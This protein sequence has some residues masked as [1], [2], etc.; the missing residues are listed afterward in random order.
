MGGLRTDRSSSSNLEEEKARGEEEEEEDEKP[1][2]EEG[3]GTNTQKRTQNTLLNEKQRTKDNEGLTFGKGGE[4]WTRYDTKRKLKR[5]DGDYDNFHNVKE[6]FVFI[7][8][9]G[10]FETEDD[11]RQH[12]QGH[13]KHSNSLSLFTKVGQVRE[14]VREQRERGR[15][16]ETGRDREGETESGGRK[17]E[18][19]SRHI[20]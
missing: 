16:G 4:L 7:T 18:V 19:D 13:N 17:K 20:R 9:V 2:K 10:R 12:N 1:K 11:C 8:H 6:V 5:E 3:L 14:Q 15:Q